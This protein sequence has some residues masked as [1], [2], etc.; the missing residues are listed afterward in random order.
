[1]IY[2]EKTNEV[3]SE[4]NLAL[5]E[6]KLV[7]NS[8]KQLK[9][10]LMTLEA[11]FQG[12]GN[13]NIS[14]SPIELS[15][16]DFTMALDSA[17]SLLEPNVLLSQGIV[18]MALFD[19]DGTLINASAGDE[20][21]RYFTKNKLVK[22]ELRTEIDR[23]MAIVGVAQ[24]T[25]IANEI[26]LGVNR[27][28]DR[29]LESHK[30]WSRSLSSDQEAYIKATWEVYPIYSAL[31]AGHNLDDLKMLANE[32]AKP[33]LLPKYFDG[34]AALID[35]LKL[36]GIE[37]AIIS[38][39]PDFLVKQLASPLAIQERF[40]TGVMLNTDENSIVQT[41]INGNLTFRE[42]KMERAREIFAEH[43]QIAS[44]NVKGLKPLLAF[45]DA[46]S[47]T[48]QQML[49]A[50]EITVVIEPRTEDDRQHAYE[51]AARGQV[52]FLIRAER[53][54]AGEVVLGGEG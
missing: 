6:E 20:M 28:L 9:T 14:S 21:R 51:L 49:E 13:Q 37:S 11:I 1:M 36:G 8:S 10:A 52:V 25:E 26:D 53:T 33:K 27:D 24:R 5:E 45:G 50:A 17:S 35:S 23:L 48:D 42:G 46:P 12:K 43:L 41:K 2:T 30:S 16:A 40:V 15:L 32:Y 44:D 7:P 39:S 4:Q 31:Y 38:A 54:E 3:I 22:P 19:F 29:V 47:M 34:S 18:P